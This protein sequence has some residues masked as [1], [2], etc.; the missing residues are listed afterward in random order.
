MIALLAIMA[1]FYLLGVLRTAGS[2]N[3]MGADDLSVVLGAVSWPIT[4]PILVIMLASPDGKGN[5]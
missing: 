1:A 5:G 3:V 4:L 2:L